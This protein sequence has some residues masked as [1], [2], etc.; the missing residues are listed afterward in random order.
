MNRSPILR[1]FNP[2]RTREPKTVWLKT[3]E[4]VRNNLR[5]HWDNLI[6]QIHTCATGEGF[7]IEFRTFLYK[8]GNIRDMNPKQPVTLFQAR[9]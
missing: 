3:R 5:Q 4:I 9:E 7:S 2:T 6:G 8:M 1:E